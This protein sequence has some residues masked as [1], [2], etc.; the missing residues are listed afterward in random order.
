MYVRISD[1]R[2]GQR[3]GVKRQEKDCRDLATDR[4]WRVSKVYVDNDLS[5]YSGKPRPKYEQLLDDL[6]NG[7]V[8][9][10]IAW[11]PDRLHRRPVELEKF[12]DLIEKTGVPVATVTAGDYD[13]ST[14]SGRMTARV[15]GSMARY[16]SE[17]K[18]ER[19][20]R[21]HLELARQ[22]K[23]K[24]GGTRPFGFNADRVTLNR[25]E[26]K[27]IREAAKR[28]LAGDSLRG[29]C[30]DWRQ[31]AVKTV[32]GTEWTTTV[33]R[34]M[35]IAPRTAGLR[36][37]QGEVVRNGDG[38]PVKTEWPAIIR[39]DQ[40]EK[41]RALL[42]DPSRLKFDGRVARKY[43]LTGFVYCGLCDAKLVARPKGDKRRC[44]VC[45]SGP[46]FYGCGK[47]RSL[48][49]PIEGEVCDRIFAR[50]DSPQL[51]EALR[52]APDDGDEQAL[53]DSLWED[54]AALEQL[55]RD[56]YVE[57]LISRSE[58]MAARQG[59]ESRIESTKR[60][61]AG[62]GHSRV[63]LDLP[64]GIDALKKAWDEHGLD[65]SRS[66]IAA[67]VER[68]ELKPAVKGRNFFDPNRVLIVWRA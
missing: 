34:R 1:D 36:E 32:T 57:R 47:I 3:A 21:K 18:S 63:V 17:H 58:Y 8:D 41:L 61:L 5:A 35:L 9:A 7:V 30:T 28:V 4:A 64:R 66:L 33:L 59:I 45:A 65:W 12:I 46:N 16:E 37:H 11:H 14:P 22:G 2:T 62:N 52:R 31:R 27:L 56:H 26:A 43:L 20:R 60:R 6:R 29:V 24:G 68:I 13:L 19:Q 54:G 55:A 50:L 39:R 67:V 49:E 38:E 23:G 48:A 51:T 53:L 25:D 10:V 44:Y 42:L 15:V 40:H